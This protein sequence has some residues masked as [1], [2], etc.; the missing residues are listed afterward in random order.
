[1]IKNMTCIECP[2]GCSLRVTVEDGKVVKVEGNACPKGPIY[3][4]SEIEN[5]VRLL[6][7]TV[8]TSGLELT[9]LPIRTNKPIP[10]ARIFEAMKEIHKLVVS[11]PIQCGDVIVAD[12]LG[13]GV[14][15]VA[16]R[17]SDKKIGLQPKIEL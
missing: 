16:T 14:D 15:L 17:A 12:F 5:P 10:K 6:A 3:A 9:I 1:M 13:L 2:R 11:K 8:K 4:A 7:A